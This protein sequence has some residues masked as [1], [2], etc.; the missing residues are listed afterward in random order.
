MRITVMAVGTR[1]PRWVT[2]GV[3]NYSKRLPRHLQF[4]I[5]EFA[6]APRSAGMTPAR[7]MGREADALLKAA[8]GA[9]SVVALD[10]RGRGWS[11]RDLAARL[12]RWQQESPQVAL[13]VGGADGLDERCRERADDIWSLSTLTLPHAL[14]RV[15]LAEQIYRAWSLLQGHPY[16]RE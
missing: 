3:Q 2:D 14:V 7:A 16:H 5:R 6:P 13:L 9:D 15:I 1:M 12:G 11:S 4:A 8:A 10:E